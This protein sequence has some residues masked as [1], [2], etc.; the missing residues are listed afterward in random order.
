M[1]VSVD[2]FV[3]V[4]T[5]GKVV[6]K[7]AVVKRDAAI[8]RSLATLAAEAA[9]LQAAGLE[10]PALAGLQAKLAAQRQAA[11]QAKDNAAR[12]AA[13]EPVLGA[14]LAAA[15]QARAHA[16]KALAQQAARDRAAAA[17]LAACNGLAGTIDAIRPAA[18]A[19]PLGAKL[20]DLQNERVTHATVTA[21]GRLPAATSGLAAL[22]DAAAALAAEVK[23][24]AELA[25]Q[26]QALLD[27]LDPLLAAAREAV[28]KGLGS[29][30][31]QQALA[32]LEAR[33]QALADAPMPKLQW[34]LAGAAGLLP[35][36]KALTEAL[37]RPP[38]ARP[39]PMPPAVAATPPSGASPPGAMSPGAAPPGAA[40]PGAVPTGAVP[41][42]ATR[43]GATQPVPK[44]PPAPL[45]S[46]APLLAPT[47]KEEAKL[48]K[49][50]RKAGA[51]QARLQEKVAACLAA[52]PDG[53]EA[54]MIGALDRSVFDARLEDVYT[55]MLDNG[56]PMD[57]L[58]PGEAVA[59]FTY[60]TDDYT[61]MNRLKLGIPLADKSPEGRPVVQ[62]AAKLQQIN[63][64]CEAALRK[65]PAIPGI[66]RRGERSLFPGWDT[67]Y[68]FPG[69]FTM[70]AFWSTSTAQPFD[71]PITVTV[72]GESGRNIADFSQYAD[73]A[74][75]LYPPGTCFK[76]TNR[77]DTLD[78]TG[79]IVK[80]AVWVEEI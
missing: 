7:E 36:L 12:Y 17:A 58:R 65:L 24:V 15:A 23:A 1:P 5:N 67:Q 14:A 70:P 42:G 43:P 34:L 40:P 74:E 11:L 66:T 32:V 21:V 41:T 9:R 28:A 20:A 35:E 30:A 55:Q 37:T 53:P 75:V 26:R 18:L 45:K 44:P 71:G 39:V 69:E 60:T 79:K 2:E 52:A 77:E 62:D 4:L 22:L 46:D 57:L 59:V 10:S 56:I 25:R 27:R 51:L 3:A 76:V 6:G 13:L 49:T 33:R 50:A 38:P 47:A 72:K 16:D 31:L 73:E 8:A 48:L 63:A 19:A 64:A 54:Q 78:A 80:V 61:N 68:A 29:A